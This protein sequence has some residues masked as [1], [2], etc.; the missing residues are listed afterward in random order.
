ML[1]GV[2][3]TLMIGPAVPVPAPQSVMDALLNVQVTSGKAKAGFQLTFAVSKKSPLLTSM[4]P[5]GYFDP[6]ITRVIIVVTLG[7][8][9]NVIM[10]G[11][12]T[13][14]ELAPSSEPGQ[15]TLTIT[16]EDL[17]VL[18]DV[19]ELPF[20]RYP[21][22]PDIGK[23]YLILAK[24]AAFGIVPL[25]IPPFITDVPIPTK[26]IDCHEGTDLHYLKK[27]AHSHGVRLLRGAG[28]G[29]RSEHRLL[30]TRHPHPGAA[31]G[32]H[33]QHGRA[34]Q[35]GVDD[36]Q[37]RRAREED[38]GLRR[39]R[40]NHA[41]DSDPAAAAESELLQAAA[42]AADRRRPPRWSF[43]TGR[44]A[45]RRRASSTGSWAPSRARPRPSPSRARST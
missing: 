15:S 44:S 42:R 30:G 31:A 20:L 23:V 13:R 32:A 5:A 16:G 11:M 35:C 43:P 4:L 45:R 8:F 36:L 14:Q 2:H 6:I 10:D 40:P 29:A 38:P 17:S 28:S 21:A 22:M 12:V 33:D 18:M 25:A 7:G 27:L 41:Q 9:P 39:L 24:Y 1:K 19:V 34:H 37:P 26:K 3:L